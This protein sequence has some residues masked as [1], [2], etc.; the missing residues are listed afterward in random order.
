MLR[1]DPWFADLQRRFLSFDSASVMTT[2]TAHSAFNWNDDCLLGYGPMDEVH[3]EFVD[4]VAAM[5]SV[6]DA[7]LADVLDAFA[8]HAKNHFDTEDAWM[9]ETDFPAR[10]C[11]IHEHA[12]VLGSVH[13]VRRRLAAG[14]F[15]AARRLAAELQVW[16]PGHAQYLDSALAH[17]MCKRRLGGKPVVVRR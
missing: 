5:Q 4:L 12:A 2:Q 14:D 10:A 16:F 8:T 17:W 1:N 15:G 13:G 9:V 11:H 7:E 6:S 3:E